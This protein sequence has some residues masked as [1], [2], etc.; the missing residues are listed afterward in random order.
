MRKLNYQYNIIEEIKK[1]GKTI[2]KVED[3]IYNIYSASRQSQDDKWL[4]SFKTKTLA[5]VEEYRD[6]GGMDEN[7]LRF[8]RIELE[9]VKL[10]R[11]YMG[12]AREERGDVLK[13][14]PNDLR[15]WIAKLLKIAIR[16]EWLEKTHDAA[17]LSLKFG[18]E[19]KYSKFPD[20]DDIVA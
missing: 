19:P 7:I 3:S 18:M 6:K 1:D 8:S 12:T 14:V 10:A 4:N 2:Y 9:I 11:D 5:Y 17:I 15:K 20:V 13:D 16:T